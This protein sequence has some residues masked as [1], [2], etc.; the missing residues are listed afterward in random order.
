MI[1]DIKKSFTSAFDKRT[2]SPLYATFAISWCIWNWKAIYYI[3]VVKSDVDF[4]ERV[5]ELSH[6]IT[7]QWTL[8]WGPIISTIVILVGLEFISGYVYQLSLYYKKRRI[9]IKQRFEEKELLTVEQ[10]FAI[11]EENKRAHEA[12]AKLVNDRDNIISGMN[13]RIEE[14][15]KENESL[16]QLKNTPTRNQI[17]SEVERL[18]KKL[19]DDGMTEQFIELANFLGSKSLNLNHIDRALLLYFEDNKLIKTSINSSN[20]YKLTDIG[21]S[22]LD[23]LLLKI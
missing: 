18:G 10:S 14:L 4:D 2:R 20:Y 17:N 11:K 9:K 12:T 1:D 8:A 19:S 22:T 15:L 6:N 5:Y 16:K 21:I 23:F 7:T 3:F 13:L